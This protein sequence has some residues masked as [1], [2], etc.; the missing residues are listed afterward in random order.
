MKIKGIIM[1]SVLALSL[2]ACAPDVNVP[3]ETTAPAET[4][5]AE[6]TAA[7]TVAERKKI[8]P[9]QSTVEPK[10]TD[11]T[12]RVSF[13]EGG[14]YMDD[15]GE[16]FLNAKVYDYEKF[17]M[18][19]ISQLAVG[20]IIVLRGEEVQ[21]E[22]IKNENG[23]LAINGYIDEGGYELATDDNGVWYESLYS[24]LRNYYEVGEILLPIADGFMLVDEAIPDERTEYSVEIVAAPDET[25]LFHFVPNNTEI[26]V[27]GGVVTGM[28]RYYNP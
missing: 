7:E 2:C 20:D 27:E 15:S 8:W 13:E 22:S 9:L 3:A 26:V 19:D 24:G 1:A 23:R 11:G 14:I 28:H 18:V 5:A 16:Y 10:A 12:M 21:V 4:N 6:T 25:F 17:D